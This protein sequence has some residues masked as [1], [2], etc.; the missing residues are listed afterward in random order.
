[1]RNAWG[2]LAGTETHLG[3][4]SEGQFQVQDERDKNVYSDFHP[5][6]SGVNLSGSIG[7]QGRRTI[8]TLGAAEVGDTRA[9][10]ARITRE[11]GSIFV[12]LGAAQRELPDSK[13]ELVTHSIRGG[14]RL[15]Q[16]TFVIDAFSTEGGEDGEHLEDR[17]LHLTWLWKV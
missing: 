8:L 17:G 9:T 5:K 14:V 13:D 7:E 2:T 4:D 15:E 1:M 6:V 3:L 11:L 12:G 10:H 16:S